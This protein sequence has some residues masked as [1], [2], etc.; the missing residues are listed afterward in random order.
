MRNELKKKILFALVV[1]FA[2]VLFC[3]CNGK[4]KKRFDGY[5]HLVGAKG[6]TDKG[7]QALMALNVKLHF[8]TKN[9]EITVYMNGKEVNRGKLFFHSN[10]GIFGDDY[11]QI[12]LH[13]EYYHGEYDTV[14]AKATIDEDGILHYVAGYDMHYLY[15]KD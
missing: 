3:S 9:N 13:G 7:T 10:F 15:E 11:Y 14:S 1:L 12:L 2:A 6:E 4:T 5:W 8:D